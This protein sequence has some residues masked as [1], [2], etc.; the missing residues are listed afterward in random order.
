M[1]FSVTESTSKK[2]SSHTLMTLRNNNTDVISSI[3]D[4]TQSMTETVKS[5]DF[6][7]SPSQSST[8]NEVS[9]P[10]WTNHS[11]TQFTDHVFEIL[12]DLNPTGYQECGVHVKLHVQEPYSIPSFECH[13][14]HEYH[15]TWCVVLKRVFDNRPLPY[16]V[17]IGFL[18]NDK[19][20]PVSSNY[21]CIGSSSPGGVLTMPNMEVI[22]GRNIPKIQNISWENR[23]KTPVFRGTAWAPATYRFHECMDPDFNYSEIFQYP[24]FQVVLFSHNNPSLLDAKFSN[25]N[26]LVQD[27]FLLNAT[28]G[29][30]KLLPVEYVK[31]GDYFSTPQVA[32]VLP[33]I[34]A[35]FRVST[36]LMCG[37]AAV[38]QDW[39]YQEWFTKYLTPYENFIPLA[40]DLSNLNETLYWILNHPDEVERIALNGR[41]F[42]D[43]YLS[44]SKNDEHI[45]ELV[46]RLSEKMHYEAS[47]GNKI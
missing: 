18:L 26:W 27:C 39:I 30:D 29:L 40:S 22:V 25:I 44:F 34:G 12:R 20:D 41:V 2:N 31:N 15:D 43:K 36:H 5:D 4:D 46:Y 35:S 8:S 37:T 19:F 42:W 28:N 45:Y 33:G 21:Y 32:L 1:N 6:S 23:S 14:E 16:N 13:H 38:I 11:R 10:P 3:E 17:S 9:L 47:I 24:R 7:N